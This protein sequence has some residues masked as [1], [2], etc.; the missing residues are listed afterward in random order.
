MDNTQ[1][2]EQINPNRGRRPSAQTAERD[3]SPARIYVEGI[4]LEG[5]KALDTDETR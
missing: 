3:E 1:M 4:V 5:A 2:Y